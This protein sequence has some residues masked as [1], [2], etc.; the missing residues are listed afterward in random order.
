MLGVPKNLPISLVPVYFSKSSALKFV[1]CSGAGPCIMLD[2]APEKATD[3]TKKTTAS[4]T[5]AT[6]ICF[7]ASRKDALPFSALN[8]SAG[9]VSTC[10]HNLNMVLPSYLVLIKHL[11]IGRRLTSRCLFPFSGLSFR[12]AR[13]FRVRASAAPFLLLPLSCFQIFSSKRITVNNPLY[14]YKKLLEK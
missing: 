4:A 8:V 1:G 13:P 9:F 10:C 14:L 2:N 6:V 11:H 5:Q 12:N 7:S 3:K